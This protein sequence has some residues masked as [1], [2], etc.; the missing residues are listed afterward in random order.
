[1]II[2]VKHRESPYVTIDK[3]PINRKELSYRAKGILAYLLSK[4]EDWQVK[5]QDIVNH[6]TEGRDAIRTAIKELIACGYMVKEQGRSEKG[7]FD[8]VDYLV[9]DHPFTGNPSTDNPS[10]DNPLHTNIECTNKELNK[11]KEI[12]EN[13]TE[14]DQ[15]KSQLA[16]CY[17]PRLNY[18]DMSDAKEKLELFLTEPENVKYCRDMA[19]SKKDDA[20]IVAYVNTFVA[21]SYDTKY[22]KH[23]QSF[24]QLLNRFIEWLSRDR[25]K[26]TSAP[27]AKL[28]DRRIAFVSALENSKVDQELIDKFNTLDLD[29]FAKSLLLRIEKSKI[30]SKMGKLEL[31]D[32]IRLGFKY[33]MFYT[34]KNWLYELLTKIESE[35]WLQNYNK[36]FDAIEKANKQ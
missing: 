1:M 9:S 10:T 13:L 29:D 24:P 5:E 19:K 3:G 31:D 33:G 25:P 30:L 21:L 26:T 34:R 16:K 4:P 11:E 28:E 17:Y 22:I 8:E 12:S 2:K 6:G 15:L 23:I 36:L 32:I 20:A 7:L 14:S 18:F 27:E 35:A